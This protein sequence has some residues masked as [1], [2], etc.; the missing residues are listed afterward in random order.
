MTL[1]NENNTVIKKNFTKGFD[2]YYGPGVRHKAE[3]LQSECIKRFQSGRAKSFLLVFP[4][5]RYALD[6][7]REMTDSS[8]GS[9]ENP[10]VFGLDAFLRSFLKTAPIPGRLIS[11]EE[12]SYILR[13]LAWRDTD[14][15]QPLFSTGDEPFPNIIN[16]AA[17]LIREM[18]GEGITASHLEKITLPGRD[19]SLFQNLFAL[20]EQFLLSHEL[21]DSGDI[22]GLAL[23]RLSSDTLHGMFPELELLIFDGID[24]FTDTLTRFLAKIGR[25]APQS[26]ILLEY[27]S[28]RESLFHHVEPSFERLSK[29]AGSLHFLEDSGPSPPD[30]IFLDGLYK[31]EDLETP[32]EVYS[33]FPEVRILPDRLREVTYIARY[34]KN[35]SIDG[36][37]DM[38]LGEICVCFPALDT[39]AP[40]VREIFEEYGI[41]F[42]LS[43]SLPL[44]QVPVIRAIEIFLRL[45]ETDF[46]SSTFIRFLANPYFSPENLAA[47]DRRPTAEAMLDYLKTLR[48]SRGREV[49]ISEV[50]KG[51]AAQVE[52]IKRTQTEELSPS[53]LDG[54]SPE[55]MITT[56][57]EELVKLKNI[58]EVLE[59][60]RDLVLPFEGEHGFASFSHHLKAALE[61]LKLSEGLFRPNFKSPPFA[62]FQRDIRALELFYDVLDKM[63][64]LDSL[65]EGKAVT[66]AEYAREL[67]FIL[68]RTVFYPEEVRHDAVQV[69]GR[70]EPRLFR[71]R[72][73]ILGGFLDGDFPGLPS[74]PI[75]LTSGQREAIGLLTPRQSMASDRFLF[76]HFLRQTR[77]RM[78][79]TYPSHE[80]ENPLLPSSIMEELKRCLNVEIEAPEE[81][82]RL[83][84]EPELHRKIG[85]NL[86]DE[87][88]SRE[89]Y[90][91]YCTAPPLVTQ[92]SCP[93]SRCLDTLSERDNDVSIPEG[94]PILKKSSFSISALEEYGRCPFHYFARRVLHLKEM[95]AL[96]E[97]L[98]PL[99]RGNIIHRALF[100][101]YMERSLAGCVPIRDEKD[102]GEAADR[103][104]SIA[105][106][107]MGQFPYDD[108]FWEAE[109]ERLLGGDMPESRPGLLRLFIHKELEFYTRGHASYAPEFFEVGFGRLPGKSDEQDPLSSSHPYVIPLREGAAYIRGKIDRIERCGQVFA[110]I[111]YKTGSQLPTQ[112][113]LEE[114]TSLQL[115][116]YLLAAKERLTRLLKQEMQPV[117]GI[118]YQIHTE[119]KI[120][121]DSQIILK[122]E[123]EPLLGNKRKRT[124]S[125]SLED[126]N[127]LLER[128]REHVKTYVKGIRQG[129]FPVSTRKADKALCSYCRFRL[130]CRRQLGRLFPRH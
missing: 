59:G 100:R 2:L 58:L 64:E 16:K 28:G 42:N 112:R 47:K 66:L 128:A 48:V 50:Q 104:V 71:F 65:L 26:I 9:W 82:E 115:A 18:K 10:P 114:G 117:G 79:I 73:F 13:R 74:S 86:G 127:A 52:K 106:D 102:A 105:R 78:L 68:G 67:R 110:V 92:L 113:D 20:Y 70:L 87:S 33:G 8:P 107:E 76:Y 123:R 62:I 54:D 32:S 85:R 126:F 77:D 130:A 109:E 53:E 36:K 101:L 129:R 29:S 5:H 98:T 80:D 22:S 21:I 41:P 24:I 90:I 84:S 88:I 97:E 94:H 34:I 11:N 119:E 14:A 91:K 6:L 12:S 7:S 25:M 63:T 35:L 4:T 23:D 19:L 120:K 111:D 72:I 51:I 17:G 83:Y 122:S 118:F 116:V 46:E 75:F 39:Y 81:D 125:E 38:A 121:R 124:Y 37:G 69:L 27:E 40:L 30:R 89:E 61:A 93:V 31:R 55:E 45:L 3:A 95:E 44:S 57:N 99:E 1:V 103:L 43:T 60:F 56:F 108:L 96:E 15:F 49:W